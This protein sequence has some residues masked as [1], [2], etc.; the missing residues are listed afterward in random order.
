MILNFSSRFINESVE[1]AVISRTKT[2]GGSSAAKETSQS[3]DLSE[4]SPDHFS[5]YLDPSV[6]GVELVQLKNEQQKRKNDT[7]SANKF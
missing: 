2:N 6:T 4:V 5:R 3:E 1:A 7:D